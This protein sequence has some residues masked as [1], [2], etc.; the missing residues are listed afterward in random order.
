MKASKIGILLI[1]LSLFFSGCKKI[2]DE[3]KIFLNIGSPGELVTTTLIAG[4]K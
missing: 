1:A 3:D 4:G 2:V